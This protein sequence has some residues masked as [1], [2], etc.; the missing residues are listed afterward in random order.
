M[1]KNNR[2]RMCAYT[3]TDLPVH[4]QLTEFAQIHVLWLGDTI[5]P[6]HPLSSPSPPAF[7][8]SQN[9]GIFQWVS[10]SHQVAKVLDFQLQHQFFQWISKTNFLLDWLVMANRWGNNRNSD[11]LF[12]GSKITAD[13]DY[14][15]EIERCLLLGRKAMTNL[16]SIFKSRDVTFPTK[17]I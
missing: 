17:S 4:H 7:S 15:H 10:S 5:Q 1:K 13:G 8:L 11:K 3:H 6:S 2:K 14:S 9:Q 16:D 12:G